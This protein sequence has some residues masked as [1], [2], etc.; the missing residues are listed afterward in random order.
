VTG[1]KRINLRFSGRT[2]V[3]LVRSRNE[4]D[5]RIEEQAACAVV[6]D[7]MGGHYG[8]AVASRLAAEI[9]C[10]TVRDDGDFGT[11]DRAAVEALIRSAV[12]A[13]N[14]TLLQESRERRVPDRVR[15]GTTVVGLWRPFNDAALVLFHVGDSRLYRLRANTVTRLTRDHSAHEEWLKAG[16]MGIEPPMNLITRAVGLAERVTPDIAWEEAVPGDLY[17][18]CTD[19]LTGPL[20][21]EAMGGLLEQS[22]D[23]S[24]DAMAEGLIAA[25]NTHGGPDNITVVLVQAD[26]AD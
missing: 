23:K 20:D 5:F 21:D 17:I 12:T 13:A 3:G 15:M 26:A 8:G 10:R 14:E 22:G 11:P 1:Q 19:G 25:A 9:I 16:R 2:D 6:C 24:L 18:L 7:G 4:D